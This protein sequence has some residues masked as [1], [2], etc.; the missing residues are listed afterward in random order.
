MAKQ[1]LGQIE[2]LREYPGGDQPGLLPGT[3]QLEVLGRTAS[4]VYRVQKDVIEILRVF[5]SDVAGPICA[6]VIDL[7]PPLQE[8]M[9]DDGQ[10]S[11]VN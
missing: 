5:H 1:M 2:G 11:R 3:R 7:G 10:E 8:A 6:G 4:V 9:V